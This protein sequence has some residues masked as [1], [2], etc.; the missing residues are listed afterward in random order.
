MQS[1][2]ELVLI[3]RIST[4]FSGVV[5]IWS[6]LSGTGSDFLGQVRIWTGFFGPDSDS[7]GS[8]PNFSGLVQIWS[9]FLGLVR[10]WFRKLGLYGLKMILTVIGYG[11]GSVRNCVRSADIH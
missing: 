11:H 5:L 1:S 2:W 9:R 6:R 4:N 10:I 8:G 3:F 7:F